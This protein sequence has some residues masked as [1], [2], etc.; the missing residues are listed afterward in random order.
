MH[1]TCHT[2]RELVGG[3]EER[4]RLPRFGYSPETDG[5]RALYPVGRP[6]LRTS[7]TSTCQRFNQQS[8]SHL[9]LTLT[10]QQPHATMDVDS[11]APQTLTPA[12]LA[13][14]EPHTGPLPP[15][16]TP[17]SILSTHLLILPVPLACSLG[18]LLTPRQ[19]T[20]IPAIKHRRHLHATSTPTPVELTATEGRRRWPLLWERLG[21][22]PRVGFPGG[23]VETAAQAEAAQWAREG[24]MP[25]HEAF[26]GR[27]GAL[28]A[29]EEE[30]G[31]WEEARRNRARERRL[32][33]VGEEFDEESDEEE[34]E[35]GGGVGGGGGLPGVGGGGTGIED[36]E[37]AA[38]AFE[39]ALLE[40]YVDGLDVSRLVHEG[41]SVLPTELS[42]RRWL[43]TDTRLRRGR[44]HARRRP[45]CGARRRGRVVRRRGAECDW[46]WYRRGREWGA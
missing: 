15:T 1:A 29:E 10:N 36:Q 44:L 9:T 4:K 16:A 33:E 13:E 11:P 43:T 18:S 31:E 19:R 25:G 12:L 23:E 3:V 45:H 20:A 24:F 46:L 5:C 7:S 22:D 26:V 27:L 39:R 14:L 37:K 6:P 40:L 21:G 38:A 41:P 28:L 17:L 2:H 32:D 42:C 8:S 30:M 34:E 35:V